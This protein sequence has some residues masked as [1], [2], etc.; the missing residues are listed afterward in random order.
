MQ[1][2]FILGTRFSSGMALR[3]DN[4]ADTAVLCDQFRLCNGHR[5]HGHLSERPALIVNQP[6]DLME[7]GAAAIPYRS[8][9]TLFL[10]IAPAPEKNSNWQEQDRDKMW[11]E[12]WSG[13]CPFFPGV[14][15]L[16]SRHV[17]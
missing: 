12:D 14:S 15:S 10:V 8:R 16:F 13:V 3:P 11:S 2:S 6:R 5:C 9:A 7:L 1:V 17:T 4:P